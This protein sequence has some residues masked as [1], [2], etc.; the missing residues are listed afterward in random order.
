MV[1]WFDSNLPDSGVC[2]LSR[3][4][5]TRD[6]AITFDDMV[7]IF[8]EVIQSG[9][10]TN[11]QVQS[12]QAIVAG[13]STMNMPGYVQDLASKVVNP[14][15]ADMNY[16]K[17]Y[18]SGGPSM[19]MLQGLVNEY[20]N[21][22]VLPIADDTSEGSS[23]ED[24]DN[25]YTPAG[26]TGSTLFSPGG[27]SYA[28]VAQGSSGDCWFL[29][30]LAETA[31][32]DPQIIENMF[33]PNDNGTWTVCFYVNGKPD[34]V[35]VNDQ[36]PEAINPDYN[37]GFA[38]DDP[39]NG[40]LWV[41]LAEKALVQENLSGKIDTAMPGL[42]SYQ[43]LD[44]GQPSVALAAIT[45]WSTGLFAM[46]PGV[47]A[48]QI[49]EAL[50]EGDLV[51]IGTPDSSDIDSHL[52]PGHCYAVLG[53]NPSSSMP[54]E[55]FNPWGVREYALSDG[56]TYGTFYANGAFLEQ[57]YDAWGLAVGAASG[58][59]SGHAGLSSGATRSDAI[60]DSDEVA[61]LLA[62]T[63]S[64]PART[65]TDAAVHTHPAD[66]PARKPIVIR[67]NSTSRPGQLESI[68]H[69]HHH[70]DLALA[71]MSDEGLRFLRA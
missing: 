18:Y 30:S 9:T 7:G 32:R 52:V 21:G 34:Y 14:S 54:F 37:D 5:F 67:F 65:G 29:A 27:P 64:Q 41:S 1:D 4:D 51:C 28:D 69:R 68:D 17:W 50:E 47:T 44:G 38:F 25:Y 53:Y 13:A 2:N 59:T 70:R 43:A 40:V 42:D 63:S 57:N 3:T 19:T 24:P 8:D 26:A 35:T 33:I 66:A 39:L 11:A 58:S 46:T 36:L 22:T 45:G 61:T 10:V 48:S 55:V 16:L 6:D 12:L 31:A 49:A 15:S 60:E 62:A 23:A 56:Q 20:F 71:S